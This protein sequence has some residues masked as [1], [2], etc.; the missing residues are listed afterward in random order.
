MFTLYTFYRS[1]EWR[2]LLQILKSERVNEEGFLI[3]EHCGKPILKAYDCIGHHKQELTEENVNDY[4]VSLNP[5]N[6]ALI[7]HKCHNVIHERFG[8]AGIKKVYIVYGSYC[9]GKSTYVKE[10]ATGKDIV[11]N[12]DALYQ[13]I[14]VCPRYANPASVKGNVFMLRDCLLDMIKTRMGKWQ[15]AFIIGGYPLKAERE[16]MAEM[17]GAELIYIEEEEAV[18]LAR[19]EQSRPNEWKKYIKDWYATYTE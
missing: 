8:Y 15:N 11:V 12:I 19:A 16:R 1:E 13:A 9:A 4:D 17:L 10:I 3:C 5:E 14:T 7:H 6:I 2:K 18:C